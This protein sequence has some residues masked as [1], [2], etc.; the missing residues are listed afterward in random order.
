MDVPI[1]YEADA[2]RAARR[3]VALAGYRLAEELKQTFRIK[4]WENTSPIGE[5]G[6]PSRGV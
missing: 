3:R 1:G 4:N 2:R 6:K 5:V